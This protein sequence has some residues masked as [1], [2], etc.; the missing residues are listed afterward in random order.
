MK[1][2]AQSTLAGY[3][4]A[5]V[6]L[7][8]RM[9]AYCRSSGGS[10]Y[11]RTIVQ[12]RF[13]GPHGE[14]DIEERVSDFVHLM[15]TTCWRQG[16]A[17]VLAPAMTAVV[18]AAANALDLTGE[19]LSDE[20]APTDC[21]VLF[22]PEPIY[23]RDRRGRLRPV[24]AITW[25]RFA[26]GSS[27]AWLFGSWSD[28]EDPHSPLASNLSRKERRANTYRRYVGPYMLSDFDHVPIT[29]R[30]PP[31]ESAVGDTDDMD[32]QPAPDGLFV[33]DAATCR[34]SVCTA[35]LY[36]F[37]VIQAQ[38]IATVAATP[39]DQPAARRANRAGIVHETRIVM[40][41]RV[42]PI[43]DRDT[44]AK[45]HYRVRFIVRGHWRRLV[46]RDGVPYRIW[47]HAHIK[48]P[49]GAPLLHGEKVAVLGR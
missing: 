31:H 21:G 49:D 15:A 19:M 1:L 32:W 33:I 42:S 7:K 10:Q 28:P 30:V 29:E 9:H 26:S 11:I 8:S 13:D 43:G 46:N 22:L 18:A 6:D 24:S 40:L 37:W 44:D 48:G 12:S 2:H 14:H 41:R 45:W 20:V 36:A 47:I 39:I 34:T 23:Y 35:I 3:A 38:P 16:E 4:R 25:G 27:A 5:A 17:F